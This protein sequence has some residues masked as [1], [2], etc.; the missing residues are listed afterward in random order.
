MYQRQIDSMSKAITGYSDLSTR[1]SAGQTLL[2]PSDDPSNA[3]QAINY[4]NALSRMSQFDTARK[5]AQ[6]ALGQ[7]DKALDSIANMLS[8][9]LTE[10]IVAAGNG[11]YS[12]EDRQ[13][14]ATE[15]QGLRDNLLDLANTKNSN[16]RYIF[17]GYKTGQAPFQKD[18]SYIGGDTAMMQQVGD[19]TEM[20]VGHTGSDIFLSGTADDLFK[21]LDSAIAALNQPVDTDAERE[22][23]QATLADTSKAVRNGIDNLGKV[24]ASVGTNLQQLEALGFSADAQEVSVQSRL[25]QTLGSD[26]DTMITVLSQSKMSEFALNS[27]MTVFQAMQQLSIFKVLG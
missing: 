19:S 14:L 13:A 7:E 8:A 11:A 4:Q 24:R 15:L 25:Q 12:D 2:K 9:D 26:W 27:S 23:L 16:G 18:G 21:A 3:S 1:L 5:Y 17:A 6:D 20:R 10:K 22:Q